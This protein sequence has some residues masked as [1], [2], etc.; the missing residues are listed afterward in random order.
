M[1]NSMLI[2][3]KGSEQQKR[4]STDPLRTV[5][6]IVIKLMMTPECVAPASGY[7]LSKPRDERV[8]SLELLCLS[9]KSNM[10][11]VVSS[12]GVSDDGR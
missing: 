10:K 4:R 9:Q 7:E 11:G 6:P 8:T 3:R 5:L 1:T 2:S 12:A